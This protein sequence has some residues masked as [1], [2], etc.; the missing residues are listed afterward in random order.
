M[1]DCNYILPLKEA[2]KV[3]MQDFNYAFVMPKA[4]EDLYEFFKKKEK[5]NEDVILEIMHNLLMALNYIHGIGII[6]R[7]VKLENILFINDQY[8]LSNFVLSDFCLA[9]SG[10]SNNID[11]VGSLPYMAPEMHEHKI[12]MI[13]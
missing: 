8:E 6:H 12:C 13:L 11:Q 3:N 1:I 5:L 9:T 2:I 7:N 10:F 4:N